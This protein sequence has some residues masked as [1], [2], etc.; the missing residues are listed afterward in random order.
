MAIEEDAM[1]VTYTSRKG[2]TYTLCQGT[3][4]TGKPHYYFARDRRIR[5]LI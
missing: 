4:K 1:P 5:F 2:L 3:T